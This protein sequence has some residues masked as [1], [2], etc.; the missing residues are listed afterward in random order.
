MN[1]KMLSVFV[2]LCLCNSVAMALAPMG[3][4]TAGLK[5]WQWSA[6]ADYSHAWADIRVKDVRSTEFLGEGTAKDM[7]IDIAMAKVGYGIYDNWEVYS[8]LG[9]AHADWDGKTTTC[10]YSFNG[11]WGLAGE[12]GTKVTLY[13]QDQLKL[14]VLLQVCWFTLDGRLKGYEGPIGESPASGGRANIDI[15]A[16]STQ[17]AP[18]A[19]YKLAD[20]VSVY[21]GPMWQWLHG[22]VRGQAKTGDF[23]GAV[24]SKGK[25]DLKQ[26]SSF[27]GW[28]GAQMD[29]AQ[30]M[31]FSIEYQRTTGSSDALGMN[32]TWK[33]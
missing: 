30:N 20:G 23:F 6:G 15:D 33:Y 2:L 32:L 24:G 11:E 5:Q 16:T 27:G 12:L 31:A 21:G 1:R 14:G 10:K 13:E 22:D 17:L 9:T 4:P 26:D 19:T 25:A 28:I 8:G 18:G 7:D 3:P 29:I